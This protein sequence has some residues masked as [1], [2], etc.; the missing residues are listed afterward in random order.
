MSPQELLE[1]SLNL[2]QYNRWRRGDETIEQ[3]NATLLGV[4]LDD[5]IQYLYD[6]AVLQQ[7]EKESYD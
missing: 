2:N 3:P 4:W 1:L 6:D 7:A 5:A